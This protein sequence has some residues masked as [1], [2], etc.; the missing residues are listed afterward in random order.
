MLST[1]YRLKLQ[2]ICEK[3]VSHEEVSLDEMIWA[4]KL[5][6]VNASA[7]TMIRQ[8]RRKS[9]NPEMD[10]NSTDGFLNALDLGDP[11]PSN[12]KTGFNSPDEIADWFRRDNNDNG[13]W[14]RR[15]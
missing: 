11:D 3:I 13:E 2:S 15:D 10:Q 9:M 1:N 12:H 14:R 8:A 5:A 4:E 7:A 6:K